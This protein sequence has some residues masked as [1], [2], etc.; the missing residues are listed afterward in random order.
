VATAAE[1]RGVTQAVIVEK[2]PEV[3]GMLK[4]P[5]WQQCPPL[6]LGECTSDKPGAF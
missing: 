6:E 5:V 3:D 2:R 1:K 4:S